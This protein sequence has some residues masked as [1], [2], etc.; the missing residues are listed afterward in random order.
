LGVAA[1]AAFLA[2]AACGEDVNLPDPVFANEVDTATL[3]A[4]HNTPIGEPSAYDIVDA[5]RVRTDLTPA[6]D[7]AFE[8]DPSGNAFLTPATVLGVP[9]E[10]GILVSALSFDAI[11]TAPL[12]DYVTDSPVS[13]TVGT[14]FVGRSRSSDLSCDLGSLPRYGKFHVLEV[15]T[16]ARTMTLELLVDR[17]CGYRGLQPGLP[18]S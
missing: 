13:V 12:E 1:A 16:E 4:L 15:D 10:A 2:A 14:N 9:S 17:N 18:T 7:F 8:L 5:V 6:F 3:F 11:E